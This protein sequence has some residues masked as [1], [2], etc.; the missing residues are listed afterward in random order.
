MICY[1]GNQRGNFRG[2]G[3]G[4]LV[5][6][7]HAL[8]IYIYKLYCLYQ[9]QYFRATHITICLS[10]GLGD[11]HLHGLRQPRRVTIIVGSVSF[12]SIDSANTDSNDSAGASGG[13]SIFATH[14]AAHTS[15]HTETHTTAH[16]TAHATAHPFARIQTAAAAAAATRVHASGH[17]QDADNGERVCRLAPRE[18]CFS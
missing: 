4:M 17:V 9:Y 8:H 7:H 2:V 10:A 18:L 5:M 3:V 14:T 6:V 13:G 15:A 1:T 16:A 12:G 11:G